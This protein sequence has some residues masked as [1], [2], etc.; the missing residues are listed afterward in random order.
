MHLMIYICVTATGLFFLYN[1]S[2]SVY[3]LD[4]VTYKNSVQEIQ[5]PNKTVKR[6][7]TLYIDIPYCKNLPF[8]VTRSE[9]SLVDG[10]ELIIPSTLVSQDTG[11]GVAHKVIKIPDWGPIGELVR[12]HSVKY[13]QP[14]PF[15]KELK[16]E[17]W[18]EYFTIIE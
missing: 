9:V 3:P 2:V 10:F 8:T 13:Y 12:I 6:G 7:G 16:E 18:S 4:I 1:L 14:A 17:W 15:S 11:C 5:N